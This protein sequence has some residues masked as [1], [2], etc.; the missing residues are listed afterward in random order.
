MTT[1][2]PARAVYLDIEP[3][4]V[5]GMLH[6]PAAAPRAT[7]VLIAPPWGWDAVASY[8]SLRAWAQHLARA[9]HVTLR[10][11]FPASGDSGGAPGDTARL[12]AWVA[13]ITAAADWLRADSGCG[14]IATLG[15][16][17]G[18]LVA[19][20]AIADGAR[21][22]DLVLWGAP[23]RG[24]AF[25]REQRAFSQLQTSR[26]TLSGEPL[27]PDLPDGWLEAGG[28]VLTA[29]TIG[30]LE[31][32]DLRSLRSGG[33]QRALLL[34]R[35]GAGIDARLRA[36]LE[37][38]GVEV[39]S[40]PGDGWEAMV[41]HP[42]RPEPPEE[43]FSRVTSWLAQAPE[44][45]SAR[46]LRPPAAV[47]EIVLE[48]DAARVRESPLTVTWRDGRL[49]G[50]LAE[51]VDAPDSGLCAVFVNAGAVRRIGP[52]RIWVEAARR[53]AASGV[54]VLRIDL[55]GIGD[56][57]GDADRY[58]DVAM[59]YVPEVFDQVAV[60]LDALESRGLGDRFVLAGL[61]AGGYLAFQ[62][63]VRE[64]RVSA[65]LLVNAGA[66]VWDDDLVRRREG[67]KIARVL[68]PDWQRKILRG[69]VP[70]AR[71]RAIAGDYARNTLRR[72]LRV[73]RTSDDP[74]VTTSIQ[75]ALD[76]LGDMGKRLV[77]AFSEDE[78][79]HAELEADGVLAQQERWP[80]VELER[81]PGRDHTLRPV[82]AQRA[83]LDLLDRHLTIERA[84]TGVAVAGS[85]DAG[86]LGPLLRQPVA[87]RTQE[88]PEGTSD[89][90]QRIGGKGTP[91][92]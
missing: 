45:T 76:R 22:D 30:A 50:V 58:R 38:C 24:R 80:A 82:V 49:V 51:Q 25:V 41:F 34:E 11:D 5:F 79:L 21:I 14:R 91:G 71:M 26:L 17:L 83:V 20:K 15:L 55:E 81:L 77:L 19:G 47:G 44:P 42:E 72:R 43:V 27:P 84:R 63:A 40:G 86:T 56:A 90:V 53:S 62:A 64:E 1:P 6:A 28:F 36:Q 75:L 92:R 23:A 54:P 7:A 12:E 61:C 39:T 78:P 48:V 60:V 67:R 2:P 70:M 57:D 32:V 66:L 59:F 18:G 10:F 69:D 8:R 74:P 65:A 4:A 73:G 37:A 68:D 35:D 9:G 52:N 13:A 87:T 33:L 31:R 89:A 16:G 29:E 3:D 88:S 46:P 85:A